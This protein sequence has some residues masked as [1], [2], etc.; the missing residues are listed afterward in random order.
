MKNL[1]DFIDLSN[2]ILNWKIECDGEF[3]DGGFIDNITLKPYE[4]S[5]V[6]L[7]LPD[8]DTVRQMFSDCMVYVKKGNGMGGQR[9]YA[10]SVPI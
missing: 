9:S 4:S 3:V 10:S 2:L 6:S 8:L 7:P 1:Y 5:V